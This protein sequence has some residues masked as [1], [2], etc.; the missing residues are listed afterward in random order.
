MNGAQ[1]DH[2]GSSLDEHQLELRL[3]HLEDR[4]RDTQTLV[5]RVYEQLTPP[6]RDDID[7][8]RQGLRHDRGWTG[9]PL[10]SVVIPVFNDMEGL[11]ERS[12]PSVLAQTYS[13]WECIV[14]GDGTEDSSAQVVE[15]LADSR[16]RYFGL[17]R[18]G[19][20]PST[21][22]DRWYVAGMN[23]R[24]TGTQL[25]RGDWIA[26]LDSDDTFEPNHIE[27]LLRHAQGVGAV[28]AYGKVLVRSSDDPDGYLG[29]F[30]P[31]RGQF[32]W[33]GALMHGSLALFLRDPNC[34]FGDEPGDWNMARRLLDAGVRFSFLDQ[35]VSVY[36]YAPKHR[37]RNVEDEMITE[38]RE[39]ASSLEE[40][41]DYWRM[42]ARDRGDP[43][44]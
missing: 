36:H 31:D 12:L 20:Y 30:P 29:S 28:V 9:D 10:V 19:P 8:L 14:V 21:G 44:A 24:N 37:G 2:G 35:T 40:A 7:A 34:R 16:M 18:N 1:S 43:D 38:L 25:A 39:W 42:R 13:N 3:A 22:K 23:A 11:Q 32:S 6:R 33:L 5:Q 4:L 17:D 26:P 15:E 27:V 41:R